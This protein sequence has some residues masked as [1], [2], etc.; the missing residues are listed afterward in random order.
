[1]PKFMHVYIHIYI[2]SSVQ[3]FRAISLTV[4]LSKTLNKINSELYVV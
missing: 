3:F 2:A 1:M 4:V